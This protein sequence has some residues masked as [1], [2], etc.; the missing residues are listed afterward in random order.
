VR[1]VPDLTGPSFASES[2]AVRGGSHSVIAPLIV[3]SRPKATI[4]NRSV[5]PSP[6]GPGGVTRK[7]SEPPP[8]R[9]LLNGFDKNA[10]TSSIG[11]LTTTAS[12]NRIVESSG[13]RALQRHRAGW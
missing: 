1:T 8:R 13:F 9:G 5:E 7:P 6:M 4:R 12:S 10:K 3:L 2:V 11:R